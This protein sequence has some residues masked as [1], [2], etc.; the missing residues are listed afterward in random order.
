MANSKAFAEL[1]E[2]ICMAVG[3][4]LSEELGSDHHFVLYVND[5]DTS[6]NTS[7]TSNI[8]HNEVIA[9]LEHQLSVLRMALSDNDGKVH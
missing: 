5:L 8:P 1:T 7:I 6:G 3:E 4:A 2:G 9:V